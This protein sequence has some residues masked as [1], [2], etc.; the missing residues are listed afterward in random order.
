MAFKKLVISREDL[1]NNILK[2]RLSLFSHELDLLSC[3]E[4]TF[5]NIY[6]LI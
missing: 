3:Y 2:D 4:N 1:V 5:L 6:A